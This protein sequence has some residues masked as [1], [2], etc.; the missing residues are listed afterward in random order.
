M[1]SVV[2]S[3]DEGERFEVGPLSI[4]SR[5]SGAQ[6]G[7]EFEYYELGLG[8]ATVD[9]HVHMTMDETITVLEGEIEFAVVGQTYLRPEGSV[10][11]IPRGLHHGFRNRGPGRARVLILFTPAR[12]QAEYFRELARLLAVPTLDMA[13]LKALQAKYDQEL[14]GD[15][16][17]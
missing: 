17:W 8:I 9:Y 11:F 2:Q 5:V 13:A 14:V 12:D 6:S 1:T 4:Q 15:G 16:P 3:P 7:E 10:A